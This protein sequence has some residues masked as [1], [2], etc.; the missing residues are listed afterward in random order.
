MIPVNRR[1]NLKNPH[2]T[3]AKKVLTV[4]SAGLLRSPTAANVLQA[5]YGYNTRAAGVNF[6]YALVRVDE[7]LLVWADEIIAVH[8]DVTP[9]LLGLAEDFGVLEEVQDK[10]YTLDVPD[11]YPWMHPELQETILKQYEEYLQNG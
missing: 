6:E 10:L 11:I 3:E 5:K 1:W 7:A 8:A 9:D 2:Q 4:C